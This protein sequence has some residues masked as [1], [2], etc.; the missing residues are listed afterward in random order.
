M[1]KIELI[2]IDN[3]VDDLKKYAKDCDFVFHLARTNRPKDVREFY[4]GNASFTTILCPL[5]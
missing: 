5:L 1:V 4:E 3:T 2:G